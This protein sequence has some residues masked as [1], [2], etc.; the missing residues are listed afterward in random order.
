MAHPTMPR[1]E[2]IERLST[3]F[4]THGYDG[5]SLTLLSEATGLVKASLYYQFPRGKLDM[6]EAVLAWLS[7]KMAAGVLAQLAGP[8]TPRERIVG[9]VAEMSR[10]YGGGTLS[11]AINVFSIGE[12]GP[13]FR[14]HLARSVATL[15]QAFAAVLRE[16]GFDAKT[17]TRRAEDALVALQ[18]AL[19]VSR[20]TATTGVFERVIDELPDRLLADPPRKT[21]ASG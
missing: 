5:A 6:A 10:F 4:R 15:G 14:T 9:S 12:G 1:D 20:A 2:L 16:A 21:K 3:V 19:V 17:A 7:G 8:G 11:C 13:L 18:G